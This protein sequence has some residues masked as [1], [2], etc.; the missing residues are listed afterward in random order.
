MTSELPESG[1]ATGND[2]APPDGGPS[3]APLDADEQAMLDNL[4]QPGPYVV[5]PV[6]ETLAAEM[7][8]ADDAPLVGDDEGVP[9][10]EPPSAG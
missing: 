1:M 4:R 9:P 6:E 10:G 8:V 3:H 2:E 7:A 5:E